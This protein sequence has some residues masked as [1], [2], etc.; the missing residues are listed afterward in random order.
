MSSC[1]LC[2][3]PWLGHVDSG[4]YGGKFDG[5]ISLSWLFEI[6]L[7]FVFFFLLFLVR[8]YVPMVDAWG[9]IEC[10]RFSGIRILFY[11]VPDSIVQANGEAIP[12]DFLL[13][14]VNK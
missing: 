13:V 3:T 1:C 2:S 12:I 8:G 7:I 5:G 6:F 10:S 11:L 4:Q 9:W 14:V